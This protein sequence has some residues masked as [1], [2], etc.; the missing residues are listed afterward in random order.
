MS[1]LT[2][3]EPSPGPAAEA[4]PAPAARWGFWATCAWGLGALLAFN[5]VQLAFL[6][7]VVL[8]R[9]IAATATPEQI[10]ALAFDA[11]VLAIMTIASL[12]V[13]VGVIALA[14]R[15]A[16]VRFADYLA[17]KPV[18][19][20]TLGVAL[21]CTLA[22][23]VA[24][25]GLAYVAGRGLTVPFVDEVYRSARESGTVPLLLC[26]VLVAAPIA[27]ELL[28]RGFLLRGWAASRLGA[29]G[30][31][32]LTS[33]IWAGLHVQYDWM[34]MIGIFGLG[35]LFGYLRLRS[36][37]TLTTIVTHCVYSTGATIQAAIL[38]T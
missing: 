7:G 31:V 30:A 25:D 17:L 28:F 36:G 6:I 8:W 24:A 3:T 33:A 15:L 11:K 9:G 27:E 23:A 29:I 20:R 26:A 18:G 32:V 1:E 2:L 21:A 38:A 37:S 12:P 22:Y 34:I 35:L 19:V 10:K 16:R 13:T 14:V 4:A 5:A